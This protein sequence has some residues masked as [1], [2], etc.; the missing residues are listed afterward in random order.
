VE[1]IWKL[2]YEKRDGVKTALYF[3]SKLLDFTNDSLRIVNFDLNTG[4]GL[5]KVDTLCVGYNRNDSI[6][7]FHHREEGDIKMKVEVS[8]DSIIWS[9]VDTSISKVK[10]IFK[11]LKPSI[12]KQVAADFFIGKSFTIDNQFYHDSVHFITNHRAIQTGVYGFSSPELTWDLVSYEGYDFL[13]FNLPFW[14][15]IRLNVTE[16]EEIV[17]GDHAKAKNGLVMR[18]AL[19]V[20]HKNALL[21]NWVELSPSNRIPPMPTDDVPN[22]L[23]KVMLKIRNDSISIYYRSSISTKSWDLTADGKRIYFK[24]QPFTKGKFWWFQNSS[25][26][27]VEISNQNLTIKVY[28]GPTEEMNGNTIVLQ[29]KD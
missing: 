13:V 11:R 4:I 25:W 26:K 9:H 27:I 7:T 1:G 14:N 21:G 12:S 22:K 29:R 19:K 20:D 24:N 2:S 5:V 17:L 18:E 10:H 8:Q 3:N 23:P 6:F 28:T 16:T 15:L